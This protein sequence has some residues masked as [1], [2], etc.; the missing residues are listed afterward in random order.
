M[1]NYSFFSENEVAIGLSS[2]RV[3]I[4]RIEKGNN[5]RDVGVKQSDFSAHSTR[6][7]GMDICRGILFTGD[8]S[9][10]VSAWNDKGEKMM[11]FETNARITCLTVSGTGLAARVLRN[12]PV[13]TRVLEYIRF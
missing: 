5:N 8:S 9:G 7:K 2:G 11:Q 3:E 4:W 6:I 10:V 1:N 12:L 13:Y